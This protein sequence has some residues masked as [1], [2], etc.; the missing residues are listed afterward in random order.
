MK[1]KPGQKSTRTRQSCEAL[2][3]LTLAVSMTACGADGYAVPAP[4][5]AGEP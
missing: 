2:C 5:S 4:A 1:C 3:L